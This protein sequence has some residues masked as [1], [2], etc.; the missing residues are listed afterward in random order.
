[1]ADFMDNM[2]DD[3]K[4]SDKAGVIT[5]VKEL[6]EN[7]FGMPLKHYAQQYLFGSTGLRLKVFHSIAGPP[8]ACKSPLLFDLM[9][10]VC[11][12]SDN[13]GL[14]GLGFVYELEDKI[15]PT[16]LSSMMQRHGDIIGKSFRLVQGL[17]I[18]GA[19]GHI[20]TQLIPAYKKNIP[21]YDIPIIVGL[22]SIGGSASS[23]TVGK[24]TTDGAVGKGFYDK[25]HYV[26]Y[27]CENSGHVIG[28]IPMVVICIN[29]EKESAAATFGARP[30]KKITGGV[31]QIFKG[32]HMISSSFY[33]HAS[34]TAKLLKLRTTKTSFCDARMIELTFSWNKFGASEE[35]AYGHKFEWALASA[36]C[37]AAPEK[38]VGEIRDICDVSVSDKELVTCR[39]LNLKSV[40]AEEFEAALFAPENSKLLDDLRMYQKIEKIKGLDEYAKYMKN[41]GKEEKPAAAK[42]AAPAKKKTVAKTVAKKATPKKVEAVKPQSKP[43]FS[44]DTG[45]TDD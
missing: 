19:M 22:D 23:D 30:Q 3:L 5:T 21:K 11:A 6:K 31:S 29:Q 9:G 1:M 17:T 40:P 35:D 10:H 18:E 43:L 45:D 38:G 15:S 24:I 16:L 2:M 26:K 37:I 4:K 41:K 8:A 7:Q 42:T 28:D 25:A 20:A 32:G 34:G 33:T 13:G 36:R 12:S 39:Q 14:N 44:I 27:F